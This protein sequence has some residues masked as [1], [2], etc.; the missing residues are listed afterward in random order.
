HQAEAKLSAGDVEQ[1]RP[2]AVGEAVGDDQCDG[3]AGNDS[4]DEA[5]DDVGEIELNGHRAGR[6]Y[7][8]SAS[9]RSRSDWIT[10]PA[11]SAAKAMSAALQSVY[12]RGSRYASTKL[13]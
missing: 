10:W 8:G 12:L 5:G 11:A 3:R 6:T 13:A 1:P 2:R 7:S 9:P 4:D